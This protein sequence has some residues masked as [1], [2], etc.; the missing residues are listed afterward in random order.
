[1]PC[2]RPQIPACCGRARC[3]WLRWKPA[4]PARPRT[5][6][7][8]EIPRISRVSSPPILNCVSSDVAV[9]VH[10]RRN[11]PIG[12]FRKRSS[13]E[14][15]FTKFSS[16][17]RTNPERASNLD[18]NRAPAL[19]K[20]KRITPAARRLLARPFDTALGLRKIREAAATSIRR[21]PRSQTVS[22]CRFRRRWTSPRAA[23]RGTRRAQS[24]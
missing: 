11:Y 18:R 4:A 23:I 21:P 22:V 6:A 20:I 8:A 1:M 17:Q 12:Q 5:K 19:Q 13:E 2:M 15:N 16:K 14:M 3:R 10:Y 7:A 9:S 24:S